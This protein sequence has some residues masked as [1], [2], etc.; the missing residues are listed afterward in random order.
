MKKHGRDA[1][2]TRCRRGG[3]THMRQGM[4]KL[5]MWLGW[6]TVCV[7]FVFAAVFASPRVHAA[8]TQPVAAQVSFRREVAPLLLTQCQDCHGAKKSKG[9]Y[10]LDTF[11]HLNQS[12][13]SNAMPIVPGKPQDSELFRLIVT[14]DEDE[15]MPKKADR[16]PEAQIAVFRKWIQ[17]GAVFDGPNPT[18]ALESMVSNTEHPAPPEV[19]RQP[20][21]ITAIAF[22]SD[23]SELAVSGYHEVTLWN[24]QDGTLVGR[25]KRL[26]ERTY[27]LAY[28][29]DGKFLA[30]AAGNPGSLGEVRLADPI[31]RKPGKVLDRIA[32]V[33]LVVRFSPD[34]AR[35]AAGGADNAIRIYDVA[36][37]RRDRLIEQHGDWIN[38]LAFSPD[39]LKLVSA[40]R[41]KSA[42]VFDATDGTMLAAYLGHEDPLNGV[43]WDPSGKLIY[44]A[45]H[46][47]KIHAWNPLDD[48]KKG[49]EISGFPADPLKLQAGMGSLFCTCADGL[50][51]QYSL[52]KLASIRPYPANGEWAYCLALDEKHRR[53]AVGYGDGKI[54]VWETDEGKRV[55]D[56][57][58]APGFARP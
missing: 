44:T 32:D 35:L 15:Q 41:D 47:R 56:F 33:M 13:D 1:R 9:G 12:G 31:T 50:V 20:I 37:Q 6:L 23:G 30:I 10:R 18:A 42:R 58:A 40:S 19:Y 38:D 2:A 36:T 3:R 57:Y 34:G 39:G 17:Q 45:G 26:P 28:S 25:I 29:P 4:L 24:P 11:E 8:A 16:L 27:G 7:V 52:E 48:K 43:A 55:A 49:A 5:L 22:N 21:P 53:L 54:R 46:D 51:R 14:H